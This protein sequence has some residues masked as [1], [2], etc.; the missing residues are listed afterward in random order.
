M[1]AFSHILIAAVLGSLPLAGSAAAQGAPQ[2]VSLV[3]VDVT[4]LATGYRSSKVV[5]ASV[6]NDAND[7]VGKIDDLLVAPDGR[8]LFAVLSVGGFLGVGDRLVV[9]P[10]DSLKMANNKVRLPGATKEQL[11]SL[12]EFKYAR[13]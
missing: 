11:K 12:P 7:T 9:V 13:G 5:G 10:F 6:V 4:K 1:K 8:A 3:K 2:T